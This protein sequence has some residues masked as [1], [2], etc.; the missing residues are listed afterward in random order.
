MRGYDAD[1]VQAFL[2]MLADHWQ[3]LTDEVRKL[4]DRGL[5]QDTKLQHYHQVEVALQEAVKTARDNARLALETAQ[6]KARS[7][8]ESA[9]EKAQHLSQKGHTERQQIREEVVRLMSKRQEL[10]SRLKA[11]LSSEIEMLKHFE[12]DSRADYVN[13]SE[14]EREAPP[15]EVSEPG[16]ASQRPEPD[17]QADASPAS[18]DRSI[19]ASEDSYPVNGH[20]SE[21]EEEV[22]ESGDD[23]L[24]FAHDIDDHA[25]GEGVSDEDLPGF[26]VTGEEDV[27]EGSVLDMADEADVHPIRSRPGEDARYDASSEE[28]DKIRQILDDLD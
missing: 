16:Q 10:I 3:E 13:T 12:A 4:E 25:P 24:F 15:A 2:D 28:I 6:A 1:D 18:P 11:F 21:Y 20:V 5:E 8:V 17:S 22:G 9:N 19:P 26:I 23:E 14:Q 7:I 27:Q